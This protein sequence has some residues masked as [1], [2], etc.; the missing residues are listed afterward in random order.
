MPAGIRPEWYFLFLFHDRSRDATFLRPILLDMRPGTR[1]TSH[2]FA[3]GD[4]FTAAD[5]ILG[6][7]GQWA[8]GARFEINSDRVNAYFD[9]AQ[10]HR[11][12][13]VAVAVDQLVLLGVEPVGVP[14]HAPT[15]V[16]SSPSVFAGVGPR[17]GGG[18]L[19]HEQTF[20][21]PK[22]DRYKLLRATGVKYDPAQFQYLGYVEGR[23]IF[24]GEVDV[25]LVRVGVGVRR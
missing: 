21:G 7:C 20:S 8:R 18:I 17:P 3:M 19:P 24:R 16:Y 5:V 22:E 6:H 1:V 25:V 14:R 12:R 23:D 9:N 13:R 15:M 11:V 2:Q 4:R 10:A